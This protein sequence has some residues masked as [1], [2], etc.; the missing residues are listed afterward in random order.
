MYS[1]D[2]HSL[3]V[4]QRQTILGALIDAETAVFTENIRLID[5]APRNTIIRF[6]QPPNTSAHGEGKSSTEIQAAG[7][8]SQRP[9][10]FDAV[11]LV[12]FDA[13]N[14]GRQRPEL[15]RHF[16]DAWF[17]PGVYISPLLRWAEYPGMLGFE[18]GIEGWDWKDW[19]SER[20][21]GDRP[22]VTEAMKEVWTQGVA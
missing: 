10:R 4:T 2:P 7:D 20:Y 8:E 19:I 16:G 17:L 18:D 21:A 3:D 12:D 1:L 22:G 15:L 9:L 6:R 5:V 14:L 11:V 13:A